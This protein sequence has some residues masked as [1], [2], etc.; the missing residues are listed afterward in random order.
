MATQSVNFFYGSSQVLFDASLT[1]PKGQVM[2]PIGPSG[3]GRDM[4][5]RCLNRMNDL[6]PDTRTEGLIMLDKGDINALNFDMVNLRRR[7]DMI[8]QKPTPFL[9]T[10]FEDVV[11]GLR[12]NGE[13]NES[14]IAD[15]VEESLRRVTIFGGVKDRLYTPVLGL[16]GGRQ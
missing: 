8:F 5:L 7:V 16:S 10:T 6:I 4:F 13:R 3:C 12:V 9:K 15:K 11:Y 14:P 2:A 1:F